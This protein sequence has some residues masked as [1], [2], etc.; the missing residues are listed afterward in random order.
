MR[1]P[2]SVRTQQKRWNSIS[3]EL[4]ASAVEERLFV[5]VYPC[6]LSYCDRAV[7]KDGDWKKIAF[8]PYRTLELEVYAPQSPLLAAIHVDARAMQARRGQE[9]QVSSSG[10][11]VL[12]GAVDQILKAGRV[13]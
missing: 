1:R 4:A 11:T 9:F 8:L 10:Q 12:L 13:N 6:G 5:G 2:A 3:R 7:E